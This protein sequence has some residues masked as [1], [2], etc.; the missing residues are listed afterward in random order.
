VI[1]E[2]CWFLDLWEWSGGYINYLNMHSEELVLR[3]PDIGKKMAKWLIKYAKPSHG[4]Q[5]MKACSRPITITT[6]PD[7]EEKPDTVVKLGPTY[8]VHR[9]NPIADLFNDEAGKKI[10]SSSSWG[11]EGEDAEIFD[12]VMNVAEDTRKQLQHGIDDK[13]DKHM[14]GGE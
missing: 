9:Y 8:R 1:H 5:K 14:D 2:F 11:L 7:N 6:D 13:A 3:F 4:Y 10:P 12:G